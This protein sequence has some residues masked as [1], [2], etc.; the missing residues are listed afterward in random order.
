MRLLLVLTLLLLSTKSAYTAEFTN[1]EQKELLNYTRNC[2]LSRLN[3]TPA[4]QSTSSCLE[5]QKACFVTFFHNRSVIAC[6]GSFTPRMEKLGEEI[7]NNIRL[8]VKNDPR[9]SKLTNQL[10][11]TVDIQITFPEKPAR[12]NNWQTLNPA[13]EGLLVEDAD[14][15]GVAIVPGEARTAGYAWKSAIKRLGVNPDNPGIRLFHFKA[16]VVRTQKQN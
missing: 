4:P 1:S 16:E 3:G 2:L 14:G 9:A 12:I 15:R 10:A 8:A 7:A 5:K 6:F 11:E 13:I